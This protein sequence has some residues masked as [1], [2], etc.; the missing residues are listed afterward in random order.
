MNARVTSPVAE[1]WTNF[2]SADPNA[3]VDGLGRVSEGLGWIDQAMTF[4]MSAPVSPIAGAQICCALFT[5]CERTGD[6]A[7]MES[8]RELFE[9]AGTMSPTGRWAAGDAH[10]DAQQGHLLTQLAVEHR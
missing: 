4:M 10:C 1:L 2:R 9:E 3:A 7:R 8:W 5:V 6:L